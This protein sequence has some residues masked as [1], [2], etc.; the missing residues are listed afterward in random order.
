MD[1]GVAIRCLI[2]LLLVQQTSSGAWYYFESDSDEYY[3]DSDDVDFELD[4]VDSNSGSSSYGGDVEDKMNLHKSAVTLCFWLS[5]FVLAMVGFNVTSQINNARLACIAIAIIACANGAMFATFPSVLE[6]E[7]NYFTSVPGVEEYEVYFWHT[8]Y[9]SY[10]DIEYKWGPRFAWYSSTIIIPIYA[11]YLVSHVGNLAS[12]SGSTTPPSKRVKSTSTTSFFSQN[13]ASRVGINV[14][15]APFYP[16]PTNNF[17]VSNPW[18]AAEEKVQLDGH[19]FPT[20]TQATPE[21]TTQHEID[22]HNKRAIS[23]L[24]STSAGEIKF[25]RPELK[26]TFDP[27]IALNGDNASYLVN[28]LI[29]YSGCSEILFGTRSTDGR[30]VVIKKPYGYR[31]KE[32][33]GKNGMVNTHS[34]ARKQL[35]NEH[36]FL[37]QMMKYNKSNFPELLDKFEVVIDRRKEEY[38]V[39]KYFS[40]P[41]KK[42]VKFHSTEKGGL[43]Y[44]RGIELFV[45]I[46]KAVE[47]IHE[48]LGYVWADLK[49]ENIL[50][51]GDNPVLIDFGT[52]TAPVTS[53]AKVKIDSGGWSAPETIKG[54]PIFA[55]DI[56]SLGKLLGYILTEIPPKEKQKPEVFKAQIS[57]EMRK[58]NIEPK[59][60]DVIVKCTND[61]VGD[62][63]DGVK[64]LLQDLQGE[65]IEDKKCINC[66]Q[67]LKGNVKFCKI[68]GH[69]VT[70]DKIVKKFVK[71]RNKKCHSC[72]A[73]IDS[74]SKYCKHCGIAVNIETSSEKFIPGKEIIHEL[75]GSGLI[76]TSKPV[77]THSLEVEFEDGQIRN[78]SATHVQTSSVKGSKDK[79]EKPPLKSFKKSKQK[80]SA[81]KK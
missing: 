49:S 81:K 35:E 53:R 24:D 42:Y 66:D 3:Y 71:S 21:V 17:E 19:N 4:E 33:K 57:H 52:S 65:E 31:S 61:E 29:T 28:G 46:A 60:V 80:R 36:K 50:M 78:V 73:E 20:G 7:T 11:L 45:K 47:T 72:N 67:T 5:L 64:Q 79:E 12:S 44:D 23:A 6:D 55:S 1:Q 48:E 41:L 40:P 27:M 51:E 9:D 75:F 63:Y 74:D 56:Y 15:N 16:N 26:T 59:I 25:L 54:Y 38:M 22:A 62:R 70:K 13:Q 30:M 69:R 43:E 58:R 14:P 68:C 39:T 18:Y 34:S 10:S 77:Q 2:L 32:E 37:S 76:K 8:H